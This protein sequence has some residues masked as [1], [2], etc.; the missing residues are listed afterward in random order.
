MIAAVAVALSILGVAYIVGARI[1]PTPAPAVQ[2]VPTVPQEPPQT[3]DQLIG[4]IVAQDLVADPE[5]QRACDD[6]VAQ[7]QREGRTGA[8]NCH[9]RSVPRGALPPPAGQQPGG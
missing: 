1:V 4:G 9:I 2:P 7:Y 8:V 5:S 3:M 6:L